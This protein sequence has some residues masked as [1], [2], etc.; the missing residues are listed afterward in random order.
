MSRSRSVRTLC[1]LA[2]LSAS[3][4]CRT[5]STSEPQADSANNA[6][7]AAAAAPAPAPARVVLS[8]T[9]EAAVTVEVEVVDTPEARQ[10]GLMY[11]KQL[12]PLAGMLFIFE[13][14]E[15]HSFWMHNTLLPLD[16]IF[17]TAEWTVLGI[18]ENATPLTDTPRNV[19]GDSQY[20][21]E[22]N[23]GFSRRHGLRAGT[24]VRYLP[25]S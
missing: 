17:I 25:G 15:F 9:G 13:R 22:V 21:L 2:L 14:S 18:V 3:S 8:P 11:R 23:A 1:A 19:P 5:T 7:L 16:L 12:A 10:R 4:A 20:V 6:A 24:P